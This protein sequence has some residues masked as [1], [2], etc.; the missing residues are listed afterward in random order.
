MEGEKPLPYYDIKGIPTIEIGFNLR[1]ADVLQ[2]VVIG[3]R[4]SC[5]A[6][7]DNGPSK[8]YDW[9]VSD[10]Q[11]PIGL[12]PASDSDALIYYLSPVVKYLDKG[13]TVR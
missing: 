12:T 1:V 6:R 11:I 8:L 5:A 7:P 10:A 3:N 4:G 13:M 2:Q 9:A